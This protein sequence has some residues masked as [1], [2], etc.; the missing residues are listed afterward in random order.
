VSD[1]QDLFHIKTN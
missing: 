1:S